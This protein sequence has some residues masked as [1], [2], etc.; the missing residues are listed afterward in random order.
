MEK[1]QVV[2][3]TA[4]LLKNAQRFLADE[5]GPTAVEYAVM[6]ARIVVACLGSI[7]ALAFA[8]KDSLDSS[9]QAIGNAL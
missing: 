4:K 6:L 1:F 5:S 8:T 2:A 7:Q 9:S 3:V